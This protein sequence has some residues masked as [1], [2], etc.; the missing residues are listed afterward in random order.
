MDVNQEK[1]EDSE[2]N[3]VPT[4][5]EV[6][7]GPQAERRRTESNEVDFENNDIPNNEISD[8]WTISRKIANLRRI[9][10]GK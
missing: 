7:L 3:K 8:V 9:F 6:G 5:S 10:K 2:I 1:R 4:P